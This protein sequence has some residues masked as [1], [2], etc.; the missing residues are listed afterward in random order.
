MELLKVKNLKISFITKKNISKVVDNISF[1]L[2]I[3]ESLAIVGESGSGKSMTA[4][5]I[6]RLLDDIDAT[7]KGEILY[8]NQSIL[9]LSE[10]EL[11]QLRGKEISMIFQEPMTSLNPVFTIGSQIAESVIIHEGK[12]KAKEKA[13]EMLELVG[14][15]NADLVYHKY[16]HELSGG[17]RQRVMIAM[18]LSCS[19]SILIADE[20]TTAL[21][22]TIQAQILELIKNLQKQLETALILITHDLGIVAENTDN[23]IIMYC[24][25]IAEKIPTHKLFHSDTIT[26]PYTKALLDS[27]KQMIP[28]EGSIPTSPPPGCP[29]SPRCPYAQERCFQEIPLLEQQ[30]SPDHYIACFYPCGGN[31]CP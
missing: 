4:L 9:E 12:S 7:I 13:I 11:E 6:L 14:I 5:S 2:S 19:P 28:I 24:G 25:K 27:A 26:H 10:N 20:P 18:A 3:G 30:K 17:M 15:A 29:F 31:P 21:D 23:V 22:V 8:K 1:S 16:P